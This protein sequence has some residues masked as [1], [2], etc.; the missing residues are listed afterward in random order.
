[1]DRS[2]EY[3]YDKYSFMSNVLCGVLVLANKI[4][5]FLSLKQSNNLN[6]FINYPF[7]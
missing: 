2:P 4:Y 7:D 5:S 1:M 3:L 6:M